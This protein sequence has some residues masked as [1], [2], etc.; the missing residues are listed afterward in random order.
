MRIAF[1]I[2]LLSL[3]VGCA[4]MLNQYGERVQVSPNGVSYIGCR[5]MGPL[6]ASENDSVDDQKSALNKLKNKL[7]ENGGNWLVILNAQSSGNAFTAT[8]AT[9][10]ARG[11]YCPQKVVDLVDR[12]DAGSGKACRTYARS[13]YKSGEL[14]VYRKR[15]N[16]AC[17]FDD[18]EA[19]D[20]M[21]KEDKLTEQFKVKCETG[22]GD[23]EACASYAYRLGA[24]YDNEAEANFYA[25]RGC[26][27]NSVT[28]CKYVSLVKQHY[29]RQDREM[30]QQ[31][32]QI[33]AQ[34]AEAHERQADAIERDQKA[35][36]L[37]MMS[38]SFRQP[39][40]VTQPASPSKAINCDSTP[41]YDITG[42]Y[43]GTSTN[44][45]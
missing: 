9:I 40:A 32:L 24:M 21:E 29:E 14:M 13:A 15:L 16:Q 38:N 44:C 5:D 12:C 27:L 35:R 17:E 8:S 22:T 3:I 4:T 42:K 10:Q 41:R 11:F 1:L 33:N 25:E 7:G 34:M 6:S 19:C 39:A 37:Q 2:S 23:G 31:Q 30:N 20:L 43:V 36:A 28:A 18:L 45:R 26:Q